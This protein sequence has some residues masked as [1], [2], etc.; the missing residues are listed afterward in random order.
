VKSV[1]NQLTALKKTVVI[2]PYGQR[3]NWV[4]RSV[5]DFGDGGAFPEIHIP[6]Y[7]LNMGRR[8]EMV[9]ASPHSLAITCGF[10]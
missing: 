9:R 3:Q 1:Q 5:E 7:P 4:P 6:Q 10:G 2:P 8:N